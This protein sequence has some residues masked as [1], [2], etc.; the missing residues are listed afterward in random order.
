MGM[1]FYATPVADSDKRMRKNSQV[2]DLRLAVANLIA[3]Q[4]SG[5][6]F[7]ATEPTYGPK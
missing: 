1:F 6:A 2:M 3:P 4:F 7:A 5:H